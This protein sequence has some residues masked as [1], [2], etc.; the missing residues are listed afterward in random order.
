[1]NK[2][3]FDWCFGGNFVPSSA[4]NQLEMW[5]EETFDPEAIDRELGWA[6]KIG[7]RIMRVY[8]HDLLHLQDR[9]GFFRRIETYLN[10]ASSHQIKT[11]FVFFDDCWKPEFALGK[12]PAPQP[13]SH[14]S[15]WIQSPGS[16]VADTPTEWDRLERYVKDVL[17]TFGNA[18]RNVLWDLY[19]EPGNGK[20][21][22]HVTLSGLR[23]EQS[24]TLLREVFKWAREVA[25]SQPLTAAP[26]CF[27]Q[28]FDNLNRF[29]FDNSDVVSFH[30]YSTPNELQERIHWVRLLAD[31]R[32]IICSEY[33]ARTAG[34][35]FESC[36]PILQDNNISAI[37]WGLVAGKT[38]TI[39]PWGWTAEKGEPEL[40]FHDV[41]NSDGELLYAKEGEV[42]KAVSL[43]TS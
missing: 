25:P 7:M 43:K 8:L 27:T 1:M 9:D 29:L 24:F 6:G 3:S 36:L 39:Y 21:G 34:S 26:W 2:A 16:Q 38:N 30:C 12:Q 13:K 17:S 19:N 28:E 33:M 31:G 15:G 14:N 10:I 37:N 32:P 5:Q 40:Y 11:M 4:I 42:F 23:V 20:S 22:D 18:P 41:F 35:T